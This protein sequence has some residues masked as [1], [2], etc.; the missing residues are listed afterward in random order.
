MSGGQSPKRRDKHG[1]V[2]L[3]VLAQAKFA[4]VIKAAG[5]EGGFGGETETAHGD[6]EKFYCCVACTVNSSVLPQKLLLLC[7]LE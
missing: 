3:E 4:H 7:T 6:L 1:G 5:S 2:E